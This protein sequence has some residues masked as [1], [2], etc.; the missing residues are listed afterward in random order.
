MSGMTRPLCATCAPGSKTAKRG[1]AMPS[2]QSSFLASPLFWQSASSPGPLPVKGTP[3]SSSRPATATSP[4]SASFHISIKL[5]T[6]S[7][8]VTARPSTSRCTSPCTPT[9]ETRWPPRSSAA[10]T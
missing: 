10:A 5:K 7:G 1:E 2:K 8:A 3:T 6:S 9:I 4:T